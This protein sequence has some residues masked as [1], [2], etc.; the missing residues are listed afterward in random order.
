MKC[1]IK[2]LVSVVVILILMAQTI[3]PVAMAGEI[4]EQVKIVGIDDIVTPKL[5]D[6][7]D[8]KKGDIIAT[9]TRKN[10]SEPCEVT[11]GMTIYFGKDESGNRSMV[12]EVDNNCNIIVVDKNEKIKSTASS[13]SDVTTQ[14]AGEK[15]IS[16]DY[17]T[18][19]LG[20]EWDK[21]TDDYNTI[22][23]SFDGSQAWTIED[24]RD[25]WAKSSTDW[26]NTYCRAWNDPS[27]GDMTQ[28]NVRADYH[29]LN[30]LYTH[31]LWTALAG[32]KS[33]TASCSYVYSGSVVLG[34]AVNC[35]T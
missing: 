2:N 12:T 5:V 9:G 15:W 1:G 22:T 17:W 19:G 23:F 27:S 6:Y 29:W 25:C 26:V 32:Y 21:L 11:F 33:G 14:R 7:K 24:G 20:G 4:A 28:Y 30:N 10:S 18:Y 35:V 13:A 8:V 3:V 16:I 34:P 31:T